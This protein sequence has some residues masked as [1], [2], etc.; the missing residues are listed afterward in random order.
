MVILRLSI[1]VYKFVIE[2]FHKDL[3]FKL[4]RRSTGKYST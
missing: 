1:I 3:S 4:A 2:G